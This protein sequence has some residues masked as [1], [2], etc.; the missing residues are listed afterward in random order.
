MPI[1]SFQRIAP[2]LW[3]LDELK[4]AASG[5]QCLATWLEPSLLAPG[6]VPVAVHIDVC[7]PIDSA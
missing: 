3:R 4:G 2:L 5:W 1:V 6:A 7:M